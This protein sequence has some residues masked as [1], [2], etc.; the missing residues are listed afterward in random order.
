[1][2]DVL[3][4]VTTMTET[5]DV[6][7]LLGTG[8]DK[9]SVSDI[10]VPATHAFVRDQAADRRYTAPLYLSPAHTEKYFEP[11]GFDFHSMHL[12]WGTKDCIPGH[13]YLVHPQHK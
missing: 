8:S 11:N 10:S 3:P 6:I 9:F 2:K 5:W 1:M 4:W 7:G 13:L 12:Q